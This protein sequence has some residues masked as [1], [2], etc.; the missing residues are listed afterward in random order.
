M[1][2]LT[3]IPKD[4]TGRVTCFVTFREK[5][6]LD[7]INLME[8]PITFNGNTHVLKFSQALSKKQLSM[9][10]RNYP[11]TQRYHQNQNI[12]RKSRERENRW[13]GEDN[14][15]HKLSINYREKNQK[16][17]DRR[18][19][20]RSNEAKSGR[21]KGEYDGWLRYNVSIPKGNQDK[22]KVVVQNKVINLKDFL[23]YYQKEENR[24]SLKIMENSLNPN[25]R[26][27][28]KNRSENDLQER[29]LPFS[30]HHNTAYAQTREMGVV[31]LQTVFRQRSLISEI[32]SENFQRSTNA[33]F[34][35]RKYFENKFAKEF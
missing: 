18:R 22:L 15:Q 14:Y 2:E 9:N 34:S 16:K 23:I 33:N 27:R 17:R 4:S 1:E 13:E 7:R 8:M 5:Y 26:F 31:H 30:Y 21:I 20:R 24:E 3:I 35:P 6:I 29:E 32:S 28:I 19:R 11:T 12:F 10:K 25:E